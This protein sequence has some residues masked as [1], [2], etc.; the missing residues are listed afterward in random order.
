MSSSVVTGD[1]LVVQVENDGESY[2]LDLNKPT[3]STAGGSTAE[4]R[5]L[6]LACAPEIGLVALQS[7]TGIDASVPGR[8]Q[9]WSYED[10]A[11]PF[12]PA[13]C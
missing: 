9:R 8:L 3:A 7:K 5:Q 12:P 13:P 6:D 10:G 1:T 2:T 4:G 11:P